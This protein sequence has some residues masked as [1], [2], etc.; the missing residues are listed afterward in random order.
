MLLRNWVCAWDHYRASNSHPLKAMTIT[1]AHYDSI[2]L[3]DGLKLSGRG[4][5][6]MEKKDGVWANKVTA[7]GIIIGEQMKDGDFWAFDCVQFGDDY[8]WGE[9]FQYRFYKLQQFAPLGLKIV[10]SG[11]GPEFLEAVLARGG[12]G[13]VI[14]DLDAPYGTGL[15]KC[16]RF[17]THDLIITE[18]H[19]Y[20]SSIHLGSAAG[21]D[22]GWCPCKAAFDSVRVGD[23]VEIEAFGR[24]ASGKLREPRFIRLRPDK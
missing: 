22:F 23:V 17:E 20:K 21:E 9:P 24:Y 11:F 3:K 13:V 19:A 12:E 6:W 14:A 16:K 5:L 2:P 15:T 1:R 8:L 7:F 4:Q 10:P 18:K